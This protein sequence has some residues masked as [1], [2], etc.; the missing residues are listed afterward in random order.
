M[1]ADSITD[2]IYEV[3]SVLPKIA[4]MSEEIGKIKSNVTD[5]VTDVNE[6]MEK[7]VPKEGK[8][9]RKTKASDF[10]WVIY[11]LFIIRIKL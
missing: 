9:T 7:M 1:N 3:R 6:M 11:L 4:K 2:L 5:I 8:K 10:L